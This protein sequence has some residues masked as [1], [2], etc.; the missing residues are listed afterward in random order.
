MESWRDTCRSTQDDERVSTQAVFTEQ[1]ASASQ[2]TAGK[3][4][5]TI[6]RLLGMAGEE[7]EVASA[8]SQ[9]MMKDAATLLK[10]LER[11]CAT[12]WMRLSRNRSIIMGQRNRSCSSW[13]AICTTTLWE[14][15]LDELVFQGNWQQVK[16][17]E[18]FMER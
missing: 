3:V 5:D 15:E 12:I 18:R 6:S 16:N 13:T 17:C 2:M 4:L 10:L 8:R 1:V 11:K 14:R 9:S 7:K